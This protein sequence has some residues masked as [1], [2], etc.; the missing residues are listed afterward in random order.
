ME[1]NPEL[2][3]AL[4]INFIVNLMRLELTRFYDF[5]PHS[6]FALVPLN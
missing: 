1:Y 2:T 3:S 6:A 4:D 5:S